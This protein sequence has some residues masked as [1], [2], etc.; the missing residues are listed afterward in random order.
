MNGIAA[1]QR[2]ACNRTLL[3]ALIATVV[4]LFTGF[5]AAYLERSTSGGVWVRI[6]LPPV[7]LVNTLLLVASSLVLEFARRR[8]GR[9]TRLAIALGFLFVAGQTVAFFQLREAG[10]CTSR[11]TRTPR[12]STC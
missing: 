4:M 2:S 9:G 7:V 1:A 12:S 8:D 10:G 11:R 3:A 5:A 6:A